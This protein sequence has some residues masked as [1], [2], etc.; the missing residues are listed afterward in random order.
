[1]PLRPRRPQLCH[2]T[3][4]ATGR[5][6]EEARERHQ[7]LSS[8]L[9]CA[10][11]SRGSGFNAGLRIS[12]P[13]HVR[14]GSFGLR[15][16]TGAGL[17]EGRRPPPSAHPTAAPLP[18]PLQR[19]PRGRARA[20]ATTTTAPLLQPLPPTPPPQAAPPAPQ[21]GR[22]LAPFASRGTRPAPR[23]HLRCALWRPLLG[24]ARAAALRD[25][26]A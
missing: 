22:Q 6:G 2:R 24:T 13:A 15:P 23:P 14:G 17:S 26:S 20:A 9:G 7:R 25:F 19:S 3:A 11:P 12:S 4:S 5:R 16:H 21:E 10:Q 8:G 18:P 1:M